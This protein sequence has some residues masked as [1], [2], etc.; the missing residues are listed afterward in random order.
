[1]YVSAEKN[2]GVGFGP[3]SGTLGALNDHTDSMIRDLGFMGSIADLDQIT[4]LKLFHLK[5]ASF[6]SLA[7]I[8]TPSGA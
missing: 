7:N 2:N 5:R 4:G 1:V 8:P 3:V 6:R